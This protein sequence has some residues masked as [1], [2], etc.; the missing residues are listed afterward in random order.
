[1]KQTHLATASASGQLGAPLRCSAESYVAHRPYGLSHVF[2]V[3]AFIVSLLI[4]V[5]ALASLVVNRR[6]G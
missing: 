2:E 5:A 3:L 6:R 1:V 4:V